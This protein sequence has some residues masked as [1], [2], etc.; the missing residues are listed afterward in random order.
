ELDRRLSRLPTRVRLL[1]QSR[2]LPGRQAVL[3]DGGGSSARRD[4]SIARAAP[5]LPGRPSI[6]KSE[7][8]R[9]LVGRDV[10]RGTPL[11]GSRDRQVGARAAGGPGE[12]CAVRLAQPV[13][14]L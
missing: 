4:R 1:L 14:R 7:L 12:G 10:R 2:L 3:H 5:L 13:R 11:A 8:R 6:W 9:G